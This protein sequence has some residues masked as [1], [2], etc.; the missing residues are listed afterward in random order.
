M[1]DAPYRVR[2]GTLA[3]LGD[4]LDDDTLDPTET[5]LLIALADHVDEHDE[6]FVGIE[7]LARRARVSYG[8]ARR[9]LT[10][11]ETKGRLARTRRRRDGGNLS[12]Y[13]WRLLRP[14]PGDNDATPGD[15][16]AVSGDAPPRNMRASALH[17]RASGR[18]VASARPDA[19]AE[20]PSIE[21]PSKDLVRASGSVRS[22]RVH[23]PVEEVLAGRPEV[24]QDL[25]LQG[26]A[27]LRSQF[28]PQGE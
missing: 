12:T 11:L 13:T 19:R 26:V 16:P 17:Q 14:N 10:E 7:R 21:L 20:L 1:T 8:T 25:N 22:S 3:W 4:L 18:A 5:L 2:T 28:G 15:I 27:A 9:R 24:D 6:C 23:L